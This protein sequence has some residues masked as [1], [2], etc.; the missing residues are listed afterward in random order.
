MLVIEKA[1]RP[2]NLFAGPLPQFAAPQRTLCF[3]INEPNGRGDSVS[4][5]AY[6]HYAETLLGH[7]SKILLP[8]QAWRN[9]KNNRTL[10]WLEE[11]FEV[12]AYSAEGSY[13]GPDL[14]RLAAA[15]DCDILYLPKRAGKRDAPAYPE[16]FG[17]VPTAVHCAFA[18]HDPHGEAYA[19]ISSSLATRRGMEYVPYII[20]APSEPCGSTHTLLRQRMHIPA[21]ATVFGRHGGWTSFDIPFLGEVI[22]EA[23]QK[24]PSVH[25]VFLNTHP[26]A[27]LERIHFLPQTMD[28]EAKH[29]FICSCD[30]MIHGRKIGET[31][32]HAVAEFSVRNKPVLT[33]AGQGL[34][35]RDRHHIQVLGHRGFYYSSPAE[36]HQLFE[37]F[38]TQGVEPGDY[39][40]Y[41]AFSPE[42]VMKK[43]DR[44]FL[45][46]VLPPPVHLMDE[47]GR[48]ARKNPFAQEPLRKW[49]HYNAAYERHLGKFIGRKCRLAE[50]GSA[51]S[52]LMWRRA[53]G[54]LAR[55]Y[56]IHRPD[57]ASE[58]EL[59]D[60]G[61]NL[62][63][64]NLS[65]RTFWSRVVQEVPEL[66]IFV[67]SGSGRVEV[68]MIALEQVLPHLRR[69]GVYIVE[70][71][72]GEDHNFLQSSFHYI[73]GLQLLQPGSEPNLQSEIGSV[74]YY[75]YMLVIEKAT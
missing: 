25:F 37:R 54:E 13:G 60:E 57:N 70:G 69:G 38:I 67:D 61:I 64:G 21:N 4:T 73:R 43:F 2:R 74:T 41:R 35:Y 58:V 56:S 40:A 53:L 65:D 33:H 19:Y 18:G 17:S 36:L 22:R 29:E 32:G 52:S 51:G 8:L 30:A 27:T 62:L 55:T 20:E 47:F 34:S 3:H 26:F 59:A 72:V 66:D 9:E 50:V 1:A 63:S 24:F 23:V 31:F 15:S 10:R 14:Q 7:R 68:P 12:R 6:A 42:A 28:P 48:D 49:S 11:R 44:V 75:P 5:H 46:A 71:I 16:S 39:N 45:A